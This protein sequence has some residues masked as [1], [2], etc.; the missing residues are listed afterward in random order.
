VLVAKAIEL[1]QEPALEANTDFSFSQGWLWCFKIR[2]GIKSYV[3]HGEASSAPDECISSPERAFASFLCALPDAEGNNPVN[4]RAED[5]FNTDETGLYIHQQPTR[6]L[7]TGKRAGTK[8]A[9][10]RITVVPLTVNATLGLQEAELCGLPLQPFGFV[11]GAR[12][13]HTPDQQP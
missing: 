8:Q 11:L 2:Y 5:I 13:Q 12:S 6:G 10:K 7:A 9:K 3:K 1:A 4:L